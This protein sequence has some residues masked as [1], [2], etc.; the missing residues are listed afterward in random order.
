MNKLL[1]IVALTGILMQNVSKVYILINFQLNREYIAKNLCVKKNEV[2]NC[3]KGK[4]HLQ[5]QLENED[6]KLPSSNDSTKEKTE[7]EFFAQDHLTLHW[8]GNMFVR[9]INT[10]CLYGVPKG[11]RG[12]VF[13]P[14]R[15]I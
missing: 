4:C 15:V 7:T 8:Q 1:F 12:S 3:C 13:Q 10:L 2:N 9:T 11:L 6:K 14:P 5:K